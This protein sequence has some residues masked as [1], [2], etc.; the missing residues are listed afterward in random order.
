MG[1][2]DDAKVDKDLLS[3][4][5]ADDGDEVETDTL[6]DEM[7]KD[8]EEEASKK[9]GEVPDE[10]VEVQQENSVLQV[11]DLAEEEMESLIEDQP[12]EQTSAQEPLEEKEEEKIPASMP[13][14]ETNIENDLIL[15]EAKQIM[16][17]ESKEGTIT[18]ITAGT[19]IRGG[20][21]SDT[22]LEIMGVVTG[23]V[24]CQKKVVIAGSVT[25]NVIASEIYI[26][27]KSLESD[28]SSEGPV[29]IGAGTVVIGSVDASSAYIA[30]AVKGDIDV[31]G[32]V[33]IDSTAIVQ[34]NIKAK[35]IQINNGAVV[36]GYCSLDYADV[37]LEDFFAS[38]RTN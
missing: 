28:L 23:D 10:A 21:S 5:F 33:I 3:Q 18:K 27:S 4:I 17:K 38:A 13:V 31:D 20:I 15:D 32:D 30:G 29:N 26:S 9:N 19:T 8:V 11:E 35:S 2:F 34:G 6:L 37:N 25:G 16:E 22:P 12:K 14:F 24:E 36:D 7:L 1:V